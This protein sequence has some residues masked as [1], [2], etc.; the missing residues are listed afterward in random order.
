L[1]GVKQTKGFL[2]DFLQKNGFLKE[3]FPLSAEKRKKVFTRKEKCGIIISYFF[4]TDI[5]Y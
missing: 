1:P 3:N 2:G 4:I 5:Q